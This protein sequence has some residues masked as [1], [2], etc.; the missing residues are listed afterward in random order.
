MD[1]KKRC[2][3]I[4]LLSFVLTSFLSINSVAEERKAYIVQFKDSFIGKTESAKTLLNKD[5]SINLA[6]PS[7]KNGVKFKKTFDLLI[8]G[9]VLDLSEREANRIRKLEFV[10]N[11][12]L[13]ELNPPDTGWAI[14]R[15]NQHYLPLDNNFYRPYQGAGTNIYIIDTGINANHIEFTG[16]VGSTVSVVGGSTGDC[17]GHGTH[18]ASLAAGSSVGVASD[19]TIHS[20]KISSDCVQGNASTSDQIAAFTWVVQNAQPNSVVNFSYS[21]SSTTVANSIQNLILSGHI[22]VTSAGNNNLNT[23]TD[24]MAKKSP[25]A[26]IVGATGSN[27]ARGSYSNYGTCNDLFAPGDSVV[28]ANYSSNTGY[29]NKTGTSMAS[30]IVAGIVAIYRQRFPNAGYH[31]V[32]EAVV[33]G[34]TAGVVTDAVGSP[35][36][37]AYTDIGQPNA[38]WRTTGFIPYLPPGPIILDPPHPGCTAGQFVYQKVSPGTARRWD[39]Q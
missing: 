2:S 12:E 26:L 20:I 37:L 13:D 18:V 28:G 16:R 17:Q 19:A 11:V 21:S 31:E 15:V 14:D 30:P 23:C 29:I 10:E 25:L 8:S 27:D 7:K 34:A 4:Y 9:T 3:S 39:C 33:D 22:V 32:M 35:N 24:P 1:L 6:E 38:F 5:I 36:R